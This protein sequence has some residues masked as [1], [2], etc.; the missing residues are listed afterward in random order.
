MLKSLNTAV[1][2]QNRSS[3]RV[4]NGITPF[5]RLNDTPILNEQASVPVEIEVPGDQ[6]IGNLVPVV[7]FSQIELYL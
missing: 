4:L 7:A 3:A 2:L 1:Y 6:F 5:E